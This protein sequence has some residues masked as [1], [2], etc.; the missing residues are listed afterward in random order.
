MLPTS[1]AERDVDQDISH[2]SW[3]TQGLKERN[4]A[5]EYRKRLELITRVLERSKVGREGCVTGG[6]RGKQTPARTVIDLAQIERRVPS[7]NTPDEIPYVSLCGNGDCYNARHHH[8]DFAGMCNDLR[9]VELNPTYYTENDDGTI[10][11]LWGDILPSIEDSLR[12]FRE[13]QRSQF[14]FVSYADSI[15]TP[16]PV[17]QIG[18][19]PVTGCWEAYEYERNTGGLANIKNGYGTMYARQGPDTVDTATGEVIKGYRRGTVLAHNLIWAVSGRPLLK[20]KERNHL[21]NY[22]RCCNPLH[23][24]EIDPDDNRSHGHR[25]RA[26]IRDHEKR[27]PEA[28]NAS[29]S[30]A[31]LADLYIPLRKMYHELENYD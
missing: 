8:L 4:V 3:H 27:H 20:N 29:L 10:K 17:S 1:V 12:Y 13:F 28:V 16:T 25:A 6:L 30:K 19:H 9:R 23:I 5:T 14:P 2:I 7:Q 21:C 26:L 31:Q 15:L 11:T 24:E 18:F 22:T